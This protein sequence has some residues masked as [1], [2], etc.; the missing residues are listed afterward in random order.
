MSKF[1]SSLSQDFGNILED[2]DDYNVL[3]NVGDDSSGV[4]SFHAHS[5]VLR[6]RSPYFRTAL[7][8]DWAKKEGGIMIFSKPNISPAIFSLILKFMYTGN[9]TLEQQKEVD[10]LKLLVASD[11]LLL[12]EL[13]DHIQEFL[14]RNKSDWLQRNFA[15]V[16]RT[17]FQ[18]ESAKGL[19]AFCLVTICEEPQIIFKAKDFTLLEK[20]VLASILERSDLEIEE[21]VIWDHLLE[22][23]IAQNSHLTIDINKWSP[24]DFATLRETL[25]DLL[26]SIRFFQM[27]STE[28]YNKIRPFKQI[29]PPEL[30][31]DLKRFH[32]KVGMQ[33][34]PDYLQSRRY[35]GI[36]STMI[37]RQHAALIASWIDGCESTSL[38]SYVGE[39][40]YEFRLLLRGSRDGFSAST[41]HDRCDNQGPTIVVLKVDEKHVIGGYNP[42][43]WCSTNTWRYTRDSFIFQFNTDYKHK[44]LAKFGRVLPSFAPYAIN[45]SQCNG[46]CFGDGDLWMLDQ[47]NTPGSCSCN[48][49]SYEQS[50]GDIFHR[51]SW[52]GK[53]GIFAVE[54]YEVFQEIENRK[55]T[56]PDFVSQELSNILKEYE[57]G[58]VPNS[59][60]ILSKEPAKFQIGL[61]E[62]VQ[63]IITITEFGFTITDIDYSK[64]NE[65]PIIEN[66]NKC[67]NKPFETM[68]ALLSFTS[69][70]FVEK[71]NQTLFER[72]LVL[73]KSQE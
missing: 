53:N 59:I 34:K 50:V 42:L 28:F 44:L 12:Y 25:E 5:V 15:Q 11:E 1:W 10:L 30:Y 3:I 48:K 8:N 72:L 65:G 6:A 69:P 56:S 55:M 31:D 26:P 33:L 60:K 9:I 51:D 40:Q 16:Q 39:L 23:G 36:E 68:D 21:V 61:L 46:P 67:I 7:S 4:S 20:E 17:V 58:I 71:F 54:D 73:E 35:K 52:G 19:Q 18:L 66:L 45:D 64:K 47:F 13:H 2:S 63:L 22:W 14:L 49:E 41:F 62:N 70:K 32:F 57:Y 43:S 29:L 27:T 38:I 24:E 37:E